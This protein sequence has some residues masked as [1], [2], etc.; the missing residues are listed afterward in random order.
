L[1]GRAAR[2]RS[3]HDRV[4]VRGV[5]GPGQLDDLHERVGGDPGEKQE[6]QYT[7]LLKKRWFRCKV[8]IVGTDPSVSC[9]AIGFLELRQS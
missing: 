7:P 2:L 6:A 3:A 8:T 5:H 4:Q 1:T 9:W